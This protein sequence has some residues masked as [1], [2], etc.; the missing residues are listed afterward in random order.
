[1]FVLVVQVK[2]R[3]ATMASCCTGDFL[4]V[5]TSPVVDDEED[6]DAVE[7]C[8]QWETQAFDREVRRTMRDGKYRIDAIP[9]V[10]AGH[11]AAEHS[12]RLAA[13]TVDRPDSSQ[14]SRDVGDK[15]EWTKC[16]LYVDFVGRVAMKLGIKPLGIET[17]AGG[18]MS[19]VKWL[20]PKVEGFFQCCVSDSYFIDV[21]ILLNSML[22]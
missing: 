14:P 4:H 11:S 8:N 17:D 19:S 12:A 22:K 20:A 3:R 2:R 10:E 21:F 18:V 9:Q 13:R 6:E 7:R 16:G 5:F 15:V 1:V